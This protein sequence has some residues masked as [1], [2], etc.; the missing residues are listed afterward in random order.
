MAVPR[1]AADLQALDDVAALGLDRDIGGMDFDAC[2]RRC[3]RQF[4]RG[5]LAGV[6]V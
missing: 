4:R 5:D 3:R 1:R 6:R 2:R